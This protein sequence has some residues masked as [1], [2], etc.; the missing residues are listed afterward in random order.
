MKNENS[1]FYGEMTAIYFG[2]INSGNLIPTHSLLRNLYEI[3]PL[4]N[5]MN[6]LAGNI[7]EWNKNNLLKIRIERDI[8]LKS[9][10]L[11][12]LFIYLNPVWSRKTMKQNEIIDRILRP[13]N[14]PFILK[15]QIE[16][17]F[18]KISIHHNLNGKLTF[19]NIGGV[20]TILPLLIDNLNIVTESDLLYLFCLENISERNSVCALLL[21]VQATSILNEPEK[22]AVFLKNER[23]ILIWRYILENVFWD[24]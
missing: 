5:L 22:S 7:E 11:D 4:H 20:Q 16:K 13:K 9:S 24:F 14:D 2:E 8:I 23:G 10:L 18:P 6:V 15:N 19:S 21:E 12:R 17:I 3:L 1:N